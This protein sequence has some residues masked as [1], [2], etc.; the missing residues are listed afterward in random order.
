MTLVGNELSIIAVSQMP[1]SAPQV[2]QEAEVGRVFQAVFIDVG[3]FH[4]GA[5]CSEIANGR[6]MVRPWPRLHWSC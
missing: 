3:A 6:A 5:V 2:G 1:S 4:H